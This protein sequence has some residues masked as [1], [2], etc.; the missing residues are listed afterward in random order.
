MDKSGDDDAKL[1]GQGRTYENPQKLLESESGKY[2]GNV[3]TKPYC[4]PCIMGPAKPLQT[5]K[6]PFRIKQR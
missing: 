1:V 3:S 4:T 6:V 5:N 2:K